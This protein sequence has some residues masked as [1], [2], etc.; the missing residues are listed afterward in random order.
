[1]NNKDKRKMSVRNGNK[2][3]NIFDKHDFFRQPMVAFNMEG[4]SEIGTSIGCLCSLMLVVT[5]AT[6]ALPKF[7]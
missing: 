2:T 6:Y 1:M 3:G 7:M 4:T 5:I